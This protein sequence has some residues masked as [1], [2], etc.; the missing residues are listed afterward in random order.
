[1]QK[2][3]M[4]F[5]RHLQQ[6]CP[7]DVPEWMNELWLTLIQDIRHRKIGRFG[8]GRSLLLFARGEGVFEQKRT[9]S[10]AWRSSQ[11]L[12]SQSSLTHAKLE[13]TSFLL[14]QSVLYI[15]EFLH[16]EEALVLPLEE[17]WAQKTSFQARGVWNE[18]SSLVYQKSERAENAENYLFLAAKGQGKLHL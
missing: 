10:S 2:R 14:D 16:T 9:T 5:Q 8:Q 12:A 17:K 1:M 18:E 6:A 7:L 3:T 13:E 4:C 11:A 15:R